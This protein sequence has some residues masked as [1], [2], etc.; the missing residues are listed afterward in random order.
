MQ[1]LARGD[2][3]F[4]LCPPPVTCNIRFSLSAFGCSSNSTTVKSTVNN[5]RCQETISNS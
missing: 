5:G 1:D 3:A 2:K 4:Y